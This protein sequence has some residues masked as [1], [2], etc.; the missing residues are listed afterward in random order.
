MRPTIEDESA[1]LTV[2]V[3]VLHD[4]TG[5]LWHN[6]VKC[7]VAKIALPSSLTH[8]QLRLQEG[9]WLYR[10]EKRRS[11]VLHEHPSP[12]LIPHTLLPQGKFAWVIEFPLL[13]MVPT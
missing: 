1:D 6:F 5:V 11:Y 8:L 12:I 10:I 13:V 3:R 9:N 4:S 7:V 2:Y